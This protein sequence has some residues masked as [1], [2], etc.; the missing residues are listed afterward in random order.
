M[1]HQRHFET[2]NTL[3]EAT[4][5]KTLI[6]DLR[7]IVEILDVEIALEEAQTGISDRTLPEYPVLARALAARRDNL[8]QSIAALEQRVGLNREP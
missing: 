8:I 2:V 1:K 7:R 6:A 3:R 5:T 4:Q